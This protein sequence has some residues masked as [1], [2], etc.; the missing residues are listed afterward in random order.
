MS[1]TIDAIVVSVPVPDARPVEVT[2]WRDGM[3][4]ATDAGGAMVDVS[5]VGATID[6]DEAWG[7]STGASDARAVAALTEATPRLV[8]LALGVFGEEWGAVPAW[9]G[10]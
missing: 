5:A 4:V 3:V 1:L 10:P 9:V 6:W 8:A 2:L 7:E